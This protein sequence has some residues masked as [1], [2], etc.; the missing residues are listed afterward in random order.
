MLRGSIRFMGSMRFKGS[1]NLGVIVS[2]RFNI[3]SC[4]IHVFFWSYLN[5]LEC[6]LLELFQVRLCC[7]PFE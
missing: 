1:M 6:I 7:H 5:F 2:A 4:I 3:Y